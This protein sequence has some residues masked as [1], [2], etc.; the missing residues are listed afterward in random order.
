MVRRGPAKAIVQAEE[1]PVPVR[2]SDPFLDGGGG[3]RTGCR[4]LTLADRRGFTRTD[5]GRVF[6]FKLGRSSTYHLTWD[7]QH[8]EHNNLFFSCSLLRYCDGRSRRAKRPTD[9]RPLVDWTLFHGARP[10]QSVR[11]CV[12]CART[13]SLRR[14][15]QPI[16]NQGRIKVDEAVPPVPT[17]RLLLE[18]DKPI[19]RVVLGPRAGRHH[20]G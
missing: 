6:L 4:S 1:E 3:N 12:R 5:G 14:E 7:R 15:S 19:G 18:Q 10:I 16:S 13:I 17:F 2:R 9:G 20:L 8:V 11:T